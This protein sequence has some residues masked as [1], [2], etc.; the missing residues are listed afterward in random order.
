MRKT[1]FIVMVL[2]ALGSIFTAQAQSNKGRS[3]KLYSLPQYDGSYYMGHDASFASY[4]G[5]LDVAHACGVKSYAWV[6]FD[7]S[8]IDFSKAKSVELYV[9]ETTNLSG[10]FTAQT[11]DDYYNPEITLYTAFVQVPENDYQNWT[12]KYK[13]EFTWVNKGS[14]LNR[15][16]F[17]RHILKSDDL[18]PEIKEYAQNQTY[19]TL[20][21]NVNPGNGWA[22]TI[23]FAS[24]DA[25]NGNK[26]P[27][28]KIT[29]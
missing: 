7:V 21:L 13:P 5:A 27:Y 1:A 17:R 2:I 9:H 3:E 28:L 25:Q 18:L 23:E 11:E 22:P 6:T 12:G 29:Y 8:A 4:L 14:I 15:Q 26:R 24:G 10:I 16:K 20:A 19:F